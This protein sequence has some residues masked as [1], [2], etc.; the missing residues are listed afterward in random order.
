MEARRTSAAA[1]LA[2]YQREVADYI[3]RSGAPQLDSWAWAQ[4]LAVEL[5]SVLEQ[6]AAEPERDPDMEQWL[7]RQL[8]R[9]R[10]QAMNDADLDAIRQIAAMADG[11]TGETVARWLREVRDATP[12]DTEPAAPHRADVLNYE[13]FDC[14]G[15][16]MVPKPEEESRD[17]G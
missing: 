4:R 10:P 11:R 12:E 17:D 9:T 16:G 1:V 15:Q 7:G 8:A 5:R 6:A 3:A 14:C 13:H 2:D